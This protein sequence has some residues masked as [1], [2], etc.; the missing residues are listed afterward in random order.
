[1]EVL[2]PKNLKKLNSKKGLLALLSKEPINIERA[3]RYVDYQKKLDFRYY[4][5]SSIDQHYI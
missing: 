3:I 2:S 5:D 1:M 4:F